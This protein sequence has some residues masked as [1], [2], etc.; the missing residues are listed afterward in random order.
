MATHSSVLAWRIPGTGEPGGLP[1]MGT[2]RVRHDWCDLAVAAVWSLLNIQDYAEK[3]TEN[4]CESSLQI[5]GQWKYWAL[6][7]FFYW[8]TFTYLTIY[9]FK[10][11]HSVVFLEICATISMVS[12]HHPK[13]NPI[14]LN[15]S[16]SFSLQPLPQPLATTN[17]LPVSMGFAYSGHLF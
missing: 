5:R 3:L 14:P 13:R 17:L 10:V 9:P 12:F 8:D 15:H 6:K 2:H 16:F 1:S 11:C 4:T 7:K